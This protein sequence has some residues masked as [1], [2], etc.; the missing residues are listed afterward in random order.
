MATVIVTETDVVIDVKMTRDEAGTDKV[1]VSAVSLT[2]VPAISG[3]VL[4][5]I[6]ITGTLTP[7]QLSTV[8]SVLNFIESS[9]KA[10]WDIN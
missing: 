7:G 9:V 3:R 1:Y 4:R 2:D 5:D 10:Q 6:D 8:A